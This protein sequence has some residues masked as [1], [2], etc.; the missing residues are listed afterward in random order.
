VVAA[1][2]TE[3]SGL[4]KEDMEGDGRKFRRDSLRRLVFEFGRPVGYVAGRGA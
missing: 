4:T 3:L 1:V 2:A